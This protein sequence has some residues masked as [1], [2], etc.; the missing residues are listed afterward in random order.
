[1]NKKNA[2]NF[3]KDFS[4]YVTNINRNIKNIKSDVM[5]DFICIK[6]KKVVSN[7]NL[8]TIKKY[9]KNAQSIETDHIE[10]PRLS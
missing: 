6:N 10:S 9:I 8:Q 7:L 2:I 4:D 1:M 3:V 5:A